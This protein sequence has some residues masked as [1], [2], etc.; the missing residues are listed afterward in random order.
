MSHII[1]DRR[2]NS[3]GKS[4]VNRK[5][6]VDRVKDQIRETVKKSVQ[7][8]KITD[9]LKDKKE[10]VNVPKKNI[11]EPS[12]HHTKGGVSKRVHPGNKEFV[13]GD[14]VKRPQDGQG[15]GNKASKDGDGEDSFE[16]TISNEEYMNIFYED[17]ELPNLEEKDLV[18]ADSFSWKRAGFVSDGDP[19][20]LDLLKTM[21]DAT[22]RRKALGGAKRKKLRAL[23]EELESLKSFV[24]TKDLAETL[25]ERVRIEEIEKEITKLRAKLENIPFIDDV[26][27]K[28][29]HRVKFPTPITQA[30]MVCVLDVSGSMEEWHKEMAKRFFM[31]LYIFLTR[32]YEKID[33]VF[34]RHHTTAREVSEDEF[35]YAKETGG[36]LVSPAMQLSYDILK[37]RYPASQWNMYACQASDGDNWQDDN[38]ATVNILD[39]QLLPMLQYFAYVEINNGRNGDL[40]EPYEG[41]KASH[42]N[43]AMAKINDAADIFP[44]FRGLFKKEGGK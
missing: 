8:G 2:L 39:K 37:E 44:V 11:D 9:I 42:K 7:N 43:F 16:F 40:W 35:F 33:V 23:K 6:F 10:K 34:I 12:F 32:N 25:V 21:K 36:T 3:K 1:I 28:F 41:L 14:R 31:L 29:R 18:S 19:A 4:T 22:G 5:R 24:V 20:R 15:K 26:D 27:L 38:I 30:V 17:L 13:S